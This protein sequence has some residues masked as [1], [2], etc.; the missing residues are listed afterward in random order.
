MD[1]RG[2]EGKGVALAGAERGGDTLKTVHAGMCTRTHAR[3]HTD[4]KE[5]IRQKLSKVWFFIRLYSL[6]LLTKTK[7]IHSKHPMA[8]YQATT[9]AN[10]DLF[11]LVLVE[12]EKKTLDK[13]LNA[14]CL[15]VTSS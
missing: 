1:P 2:L 14:D 12:K 5:C 7:C 9:G 6:M 4:L 11:Y 3:T 8:I 13:C 10:H 15:V